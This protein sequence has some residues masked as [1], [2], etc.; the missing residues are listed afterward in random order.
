VPNAIVP[1]AFSIEEGFGL[2]AH[3]EKIIGVDT[4]L[5]HVSAALNKPTV[6][7]YCASYRENAEGFWSNQIK[8]L[9]NNGQPPTLEDV[10][11][12]L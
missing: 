7:I 2:I 5:V 4:G 3:A 9:G 11:A 6:E 1:K 10:L 8:N 12:A